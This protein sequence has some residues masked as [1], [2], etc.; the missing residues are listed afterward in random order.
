M[1]QESDYP[2]GAFDAEKALAKTLTDIET[3]TFEIP[4][5]EARCTVAFSTETREIVR[6]LPWA[7]LPQGLTTDYIDTDAYQRRRDLF[8]AARDAMKSIILA[9]AVKPENVAS[10]AVDQAEQIIAEL[11][12]REAARKGA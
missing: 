4:S 10:V 1:K 9:G 6:I 11:E 12:R 7:D 8:D 3:P 5:V 2:P